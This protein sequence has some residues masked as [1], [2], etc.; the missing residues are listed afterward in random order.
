MATRA[1]RSARHTTASSSS[2]SQLLDEAS[3][4]EPHEYRNAE[5]TLTKLLHLMRR[6]ILPA[7]LVPAL[8]TLHDAVIDAP[9][10][11]CHLLN[12]SHDELGVIVDGLA[13]PLRPVVA[14]ALS[15]TCKGLRTPLQAALEVLQERHARANRLC[16]KMDTSYWQL[17]DVKELEWEEK[18]LGADDMATLGMVL[19]WMPGL[20]LLDLDGNQLGDAGVQALFEGLGPAAAPSLAYLWLGRNLFGPAGAEGLSAALRRGAMP[21]L[22][23]LHL[24]DNLLGNQ[25]VKALAMPLRQLPAL[26]HLGMYRCNMGDDGL[27]SL[28]AGLGKDDFKLVT[29]LYLDGNQLT[30]AGCATLIASLKAGALPEIGTVDT[31]GTDTF[32][33]H[34][35]NEMLADLDA[36]VEAVYQLK[37]AANA[38]RNR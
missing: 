23:E 17:R 32:S 14:V 36:A 22:E 20:C 8:N 19:P 7:N 30:D 25:G 15:S 13:D 29:D 12:L 37:R 5:Q 6:G 34:A 38:R 16:Q 18:D 3:L 2:S 35:S 33:V 28:L 10:F 21:K 4:A 1:T 9:C 24:S 27:A 26:H 11:S 31:L